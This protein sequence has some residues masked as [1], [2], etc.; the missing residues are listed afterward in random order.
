MSQTTNHIYKQLST[1]K[2]H[3]C[4]HQ[5]K[6]VE[7]IHHLEILDLFFSG[8]TC[9]RDDF[10]SPLFWVS[11]SRFFFRW[12]ANSKGNHRRTRKY[13]NQE[14]AL[15]HWAILQE[16]VVVFCLFSF[17]LQKKVFVGPPRHRPC[18]IE[19]YYGDIPTTRATTGS[20]QGVHG[21]SFLISRCPH[22]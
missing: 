18:P 2:S 12:V 3:N 4:E 22:L 21:K 11:W 17:R 15:D 14:G 19:V 1:C 6:W 13:D 16:T 20:W 8:K 10:R 7:L 5:R 9:F